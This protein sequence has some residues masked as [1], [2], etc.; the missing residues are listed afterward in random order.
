MIGNNLSKIRKERGYSLSEL[1]EL[2]NISK[3]YLSNIERSINKNPSIE[4]LQKIST[5]LQID[6]ITLISPIHTL[7]NYVIEPEWMD[8]LNELKDLGVEKDHLKQYQQ[9]IE[10]IRWK[11]EKLSDK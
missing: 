10:F 6:I 4:V 3:S 9:L 11:N 5:V 7:D 2:T 1:S 8:F